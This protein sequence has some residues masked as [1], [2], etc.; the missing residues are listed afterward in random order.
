MDRPRHEPFARARLPAEEKRRRTRCRRCALQ[1]LLELLTQPPD[2]GAVANDLRQGG[3]IADLISA[4]GRL[5]KPVGHAHL[6]V[7]RRRG[8]TITPRFF[9]LV[10]ALAEPREPGVAVRDSGR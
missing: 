8:R 9:R 3:H 2:A 1:D 4:F 5:F 6:A 10:P 7:H